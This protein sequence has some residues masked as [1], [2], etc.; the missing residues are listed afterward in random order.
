MQ[1]TC[2]D[3]SNY[4]RNHKRNVATDILTVSVGDNN[5]TIV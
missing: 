2:H 4:R 5:N 3:I 1:V